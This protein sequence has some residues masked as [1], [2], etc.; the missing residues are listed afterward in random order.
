MR[1]DKTEA[2]KA[3]FIRRKGADPSVTAEANRHLLAALRDAPGRNVS[4]YWPIRTEIDPRP[5]MVELAQSHVLC[6]PD[7]AGEGRPLVFRRWRPGAEMIP[8]AFGTSWPADPELVV[9]ETLI[10]P[11]A[12]FTDDGYRLGYGGGFYDRTLEQ[13]RKKGPVTA[14]GFA[15]EAQ[16]ADSLPLEATDQPLDALVT[17]TGIRRFA[18]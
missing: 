3:A 5:S 8:G 7:V 4:G 10:V 1:G 16:R 12:A 15:Y 18:R 17:E 14:I 2:R 11:L 13:L 9:P 6:L